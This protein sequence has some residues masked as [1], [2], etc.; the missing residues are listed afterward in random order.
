MGVGLNK[1]TLGAADK[2]M[3]GAV[4]EKEDGVGV[5]L[6]GEVAIGALTEGA[7]V[8]ASVKSDD[9]VADEEAVGELDGV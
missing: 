7:V 4:V 2:A 6:V 5:P 3:L 8:G 9:C 1:L